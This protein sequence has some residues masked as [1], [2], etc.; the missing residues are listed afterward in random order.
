MTTAA[1]PFEVVRGQTYVPCGPL[2]WQRSK[3]FVVDLVDGDRVKVWDP[4]GGPKG[5]GG[6][7]WVG[8]RNLHETGLTKQGKERRTGFRLHSGPPTKGQELCGSCMTWV[9]GDD[10]AVWAL[11]Y[12]HSTCKPCKAEIDER[13][14]KITS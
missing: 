9:D 13:Y 1:P 14:G 12:G 7:R 10:L 8:R 4:T 11:G 2:N 5:L 3:P 6:H